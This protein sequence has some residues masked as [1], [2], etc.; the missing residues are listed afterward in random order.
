MTH[1]DHGA[2]AADA[3]VDAW[4]RTSL[5]RV[6]IAAQK[7]ACRQL[8]PP[9]YYARSVQ[10]GLAW[11]GYLPVSE[12]AVR[13]VVDTARCPYHSEPSRAAV[14][15]ARAAATT[16][17]RA[18]RAYRVVAEATAL[19]FPAQSLD[20]AI[21]PH[22]L[23]F[24]PA[25]HAVLRQVQALLTAR[26]CVAII[27]F[28][29]IGCYGVWR[30][31]GQWL[32]RRGALSH[33]QSHGQFYSVGRVQDWLT[34]LGFELVAAAMLAYRPPLQSVRWRKR[35]VCLEAAGERW[36]PGLGGVYII[37][38]RRRETPFT[39]VRANRWSHFLPGLVA[40]PQ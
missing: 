35:L 14:P 23:D 19:P 6:I 3:C 2:T 8:L 31:G 11:A 18:P 9:G 1:H 30:W 28:N 10:V 5:G 36:W 27:G 20:L 15:K 22:T 38:A 29:C 40:S 37:V 25:P 16:M 26:G 24:S 33:G 13:Y 12:G 4:F 21:L 17:K 34:L 39:T 32:G 7:R